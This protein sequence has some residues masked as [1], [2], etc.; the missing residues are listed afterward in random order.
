MGD[1]P[2]NDINSTEL[3]YIVHI[4]SQTWTETDQTGNKDPE[5]K[6]AD[7]GFIKI[8]NFNTQPLTYQKGSI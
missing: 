6:R 4:V 1:K 2:I 8:L 3:N 7:E 5:N